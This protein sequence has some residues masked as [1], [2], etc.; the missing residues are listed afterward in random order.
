[1][2]NVRSGRDPH[3][4]HTAHTPP[5]TPHTPHQRSAISLF[6]CT[7]TP[8][9]APFVPSSSALILM[10]ICPSQCLFSH[11]F[12]TYE[13]LNRDCDVQIYIG[14]TSR[15]TGYWCQEKVTVQ[16]LS[17]CQNRRIGPLSRGFRM[18][19]LFSLVFAGG[20]TAVHDSGDATAVARQM[21]VTTARL[22]RPVPPEL[23]NLC[24]WLRT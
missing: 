21:P 10:S 3:T 16:M 20:S 1:M 2:S 13:W 14:I 5:H 22:A 23:V 24:C 18:N 7:F 17:K 8:S 9:I 12:T 19:R 4:A 11:S 15:W 6:L